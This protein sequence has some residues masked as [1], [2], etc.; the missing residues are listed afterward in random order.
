MTWLSSLFRSK[1]S[2]PDYPPVSDFSGIGTD[3]HSHLI[4]GIDDGSS[5]IEDSLTMIKGLHELGFRKV[6]TTPHIMSDYF[7]NT[8]EIILEGLENVREAVKREGISM[9]L[10]A[11]AEYYV[12][13]AFVQMVN[14]HDKLLTIS[15]K[16][17]LIE[18]SYINPPDNLYN[19]VF[20]LALQGYVPLLAH[21]ERYPFWYGKYDVYE[22]LRDMGT[23]FQLNTNSLVG[24]YGPAAKHCAESLID[25]QMIDFI[26]SDMHGV[27]HLE[28][29]RHVANEKYFWKLAD[30]GI[31]NSTL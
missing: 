4:P 31:R 28:A 27:R 8:P 18:V 3:I 1:R 24:Y 7:R 26:G 21:P 5:S 6:V 17:V 2:S 11:A 16:Y 30:Q 19:V 20:E 14:R 9:E 12:D 22:R 15:G 23:L 29:L 25:R 10:H 13:E